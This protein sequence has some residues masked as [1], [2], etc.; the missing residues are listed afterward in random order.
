L[1]IFFRARFDD[2]IALST[3]PD[4]PATHWGHDVRIL[5]EA[6]EV[7]PGDEIPLVATLEGNYGRQKLRLALA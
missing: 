4:A 6:R 1:V 7:Q 5:A 2:E 3:A